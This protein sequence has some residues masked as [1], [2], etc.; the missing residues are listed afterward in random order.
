MTN[1]EDTLQPPPG[2]GPGLGQRRTRKRWPYVSGAILVVLVIGITIC[3]RINLNEFVIV[4]GQAQAVGP[5][6]SVPADQAHKTTGQFLLTDVG[7]A[8]VTVGNW[9]YYKYLDSNA[10]FYP[11][12][13]FIEPGTN[14]TEYDDEGP[15]EMTESQLTAAAVSLRQLGYDVPYHDAGVLVWE[16]EPGTD[17]YKVLQIGDVITAI[18]GTPTPNVDALQTVVQQHRPGETVTIT[19][20]SI[21]DPEKGH[22]LKVALTSA[23]ENGM[24]VPIIGLLN[25]Y[26]QPGWDY[27]FQVSVNLNNIGG[28]SAGLAFTLGI[29]DSLSGGDL[30]GGKTIAATGTICPDGS[31][32]E[33]GGVPQKTVAVENAGAKVFFVPEAELSQAKSK[34]NGSLRIYGVT[35]LAQ[36]LKD[37]ESLGGNLGTA[38]QGPPAGSGGHSLPSNNPYAFPCGL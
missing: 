38:A 23:K 1:S 16:T 2:Q 12:S 14:E 30:T 32:G 37:L 10:V 35:T 3:F 4:P 24:V 25:P 36:A 11:K 26:T 21:T 34:A 19:V 7:V 8:D 6:I 18:D 29:L 31:V 13:D 9:L 17:A 33:V 22:D 28:P 5:L 27:P 15:V 20:G